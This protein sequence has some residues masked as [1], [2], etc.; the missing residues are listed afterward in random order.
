MVKL[1]IKNITF[2]LCRLSLD[3]NINSD[4]EIIIIVKDVLNNE[5]KYKIEFEMIKD[6]NIACISNIIEIK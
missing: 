3:E 5:Y 2:Y 1:L 6:R 4:D